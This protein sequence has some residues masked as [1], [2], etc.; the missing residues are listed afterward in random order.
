[1]GLN[2]T[3][4]SLT[5]AEY[6]LTLS[7][8]ND[9]YRTLTPIQGEFHLNVRSKLRIEK[10]IRVD[11]VGQLLEN[12]RYGS[13]STR[14]SSQAN[15]NNNNIFLTYSCSLIT[16]HENGTARTIKQQQVNYP[17]RI[18]LGSNLPPSCE[19]KEFS[20][21]YYL[22]IF[23]DGRL[24][25]NTHKQITIAPQAPQL[26]VPLPC[27]VTGKISALRKDFCSNRSFF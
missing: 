3:K 6:S 10:E 26:T 25:P 9:F 11:L 21:V 22:E 24:L 17:F 15:N 27:K 16:S 1:M 20:I 7:S 19:F 2:S 4:S 8:A 12:K 14:N 13:R 18:P 5:N 23:H